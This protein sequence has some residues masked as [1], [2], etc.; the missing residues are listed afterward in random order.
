MEQLF[1]NL[2][3]NALKFTS[4]KRKPV[5]SITTFPVDKSQVSSFPR[6]NPSTTY[7]EIIVQ[8]NGIGFNA[9]YAEQIFNIFQR[10]YDNK[11][12]PGTGI[13]LAL[14]RTIVNNHDGEIYALSKENKGAAF[15]IILPANH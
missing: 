1:H 11:D 10:L 14:C 2:I 6:L 15:H 8:D 7:Y 12:F 9:A 4:K 5:I 13:G 3:S